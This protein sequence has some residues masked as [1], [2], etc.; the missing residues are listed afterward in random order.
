MIKPT[1]I[2]IVIAS[3]FTGCTDRLTDRHVTNTVADELNNRYNNTSGVCINRTA[4]FH[5]NGALVRVTD[6]VLSSEQERDRNAAS[7]SYIRADTG[8]KRLYGNTRYGIVLNSLPVHGVSVLTVRCSYVINAGTDFRPD[9]C[10]RTNNKQPGF[11]LAWSGPC[12]PQ[13]VVDNKTWFDHY[14]KI[15]GVQ[16]YTC[17]FK[18]SADEFA[19]SIKARSTLPESVRTGWNE[20]VTTAW[21]TS[22]LNH[23]PF[24]AFFYSNQAP[25]NLEGARAL[26]R[27]FYSYTGTRLPIVRLDL[28]SPTAAVFSYSVEDQTL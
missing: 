4:A 22:N 18:P 27:E 7:F 1:A 12:V 8:S 26:M 28:N 23:L 16:S 19:L 24:Q 15:Q 5:C 6:T 11:D 3:T 20:V 10:G 21:D 17:S 2:L 14:T 9:A 13:G 25:E